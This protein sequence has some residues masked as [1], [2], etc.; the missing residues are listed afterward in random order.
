MEKSLK[1]L[2]SKEAI[3]HVIHLRTSNYSQNGLILRAEAEKEM[4]T[5]NQE[6]LD[7]IIQ[8]KARSWLLESLSKFCFLQNRVNS[9]IGNSQNIQNDEM[10]WG[11][12]FGNQN[13]KTR[14]NSEYK[15]FL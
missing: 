5:V 4:K 7:I 9:S 8:E 13:E 2:Q 14:S 10:A 15:G 6:N 11:N 12:Y 1:S 3:K